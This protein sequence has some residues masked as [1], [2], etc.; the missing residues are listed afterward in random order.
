MK[1]AQ[2]VE[3][4]SI[5]NDSPKRARDTVVTDEFFKA[6]FR[7]PSES[8]PPLPPREKVEA[9]PAVNHVLNSAPVLINDSVIIADKPGTGRNLTQIKPSTAPAYLSRPKAAGVS[10][11]KPPSTGVLF[12]V[13]TRELP[14]PD[15]VK[16]TRKLFESENSKKAKSPASLVKSQSTSSLY[17]KPAVVKPEKLAA[18]ASSAEKPSAGRKRSEEDLHKST[19]TSNASRALTGSPARRGATKPGRSSSP[20]QTT[21]SLRRHSASSPSRNKSPVKHSSPRVTRP[22]IPA[23]PSHLSP[24]VT[25]TNANRSSIKSADLPVKVG[26]SKSIGSGQKPGAKYVAENGGGGVSRGSEVQSVRLSLQPVKKI[27]T[28]AP[29]L[30]SPAR[31]EQELGEGFKQ[32]SKDSINNIRKEANVINFNFSDQESKSPL[33]ELI[34]PGR[35]AYPHP[36]SEKG[37]AGRPS[38]P[39]PPRP[40]ELTGRSGKPRASDPAEQKPY[41]TNKQA[42]YITFTRSSKFLIYRLKLEI[43]TLNFNL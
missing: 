30:P 21:N 7:P 40:S 37:G 33:P 16:E 17:A 1:R 5:L 26:S 10:T 28:E 43:I 34:K 29:S 14:A 13:K 12:G 4:L 3:V 19:L 25:K 38:E 8:P 42:S 35:P 6:E 20:R 36:T 24:I 32:I 22:A 18:K 39:V 41:S 23:K 9:G 27:P 15:T 2:S 31:T 11:P